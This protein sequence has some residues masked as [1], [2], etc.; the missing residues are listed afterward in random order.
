MAK[1]EAKSTDDYLVSALLNQYR[2]HLKATRKSGV[3]GVFEIVAK[4]LTH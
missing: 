1:G 4:G 3:P 2:S